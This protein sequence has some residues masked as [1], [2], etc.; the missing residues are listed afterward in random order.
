VCEF[1]WRFE[2]GCC[3]D[4]GFVLSCGGGLWSVRGG[5]VVSSVE[6]GVCG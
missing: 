6:A 4:E 2:V 3:V 5:D 1:W